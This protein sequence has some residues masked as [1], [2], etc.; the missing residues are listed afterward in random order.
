MLFPM[1]ALPRPDGMGPTDYA[2]RKSP[3][4]LTILIIQTL[5]VMM[6]CYMLLDI[7]GGFI[8]GVAVA[9][10]WYAWKEDFHITFVCYWGL[11][12]LFQG[13]MDFVKFLDE[14]VKSGMPLFSRQLPRSYNLASATLIMIPISLWLGAAFAY[15]AYKNHSENSALVSHNGGGQAAPGRAQQ[16]T[17]QQPQRTYQSFPG[18]GQRLGD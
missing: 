16:Q 1:P 13:V 4:M 2:K 11:F 12:G 10:G 6:R 3:F 17:Q 14:Y 7:M 15:S 18:T 5:V 8:M 9:L